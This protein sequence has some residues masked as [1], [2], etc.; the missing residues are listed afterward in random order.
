VLEGFASGSAVRPRTM[1]AS[2]IDRAIALFQR[3][4]ARDPNQIVVDGKLAP[5]Q[6]VQ[7][8][9]ILAWVLRLNPQASDALRLAAYAQHLRRWEVPRETYP[10]GRVGYLK[11]RKDL[12]KFHA[13]R[14]AETLQEAGVAPATIEA[15]RQLNLKQGLTTN[16]ET[17][18]I[19]DALCLT[20]LEFELDEFAAKHEPAKVVDILGKTWRKMSPEARRAAAELPLSPN[21]RRL[22]E[23]ALAP[24]G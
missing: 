7:A 10:S 21:A 8:E 3:A 24:P 18:T 17:Q 13:D 15:V 5:K 22:V 20:F 19:E 11:W 6:L 14:A 2:E 23:A 12:S 16:P 9:R 4:N 1:Q